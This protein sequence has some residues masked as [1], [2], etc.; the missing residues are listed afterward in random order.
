[1]HTP[2]MLSSVVFI[3]AWLWIPNFSELLDTQCHME[4]EKVLAILHYGESHSQFCSPLLSSIVRIFAKISSLGNVILLD[5]VLFW[6]DELKGIQMPS[7]IWTPS[8]PQH[9]QAHYP[10]LVIQVSC[11]AMAIFQ[12]TLWSL[13]VSTVLSESAFINLIC[14]HKNTTSFGEEK[15]IANKFT[16]KT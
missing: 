16:D 3:T 12:S 15:Q 2:S 11:S 14:H 4:H 13:L 9:I 1:M 5:S 7:S 8:C 10:S 6:K